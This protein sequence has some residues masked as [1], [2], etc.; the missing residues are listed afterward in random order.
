VAADNYFFCKKVASYRYR[1]GPP[2]GVLLFG[3]ADP[4]GEG[5][6]LPNPGAAAPPP[7]NDAP[8]PPNGL[9]AGT[10]ADPNGLGAGTEADPK[11][12]GAGADANPPAP[13]VEF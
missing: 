9:G 13:N 11:G 10:E 3:I 12:L 4:K 5:A 8:P 2:N 1:L 7:P 6:P